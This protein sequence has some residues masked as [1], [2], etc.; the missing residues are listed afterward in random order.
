M[1]YWKEGKQH[2]IGKY[3]DENKER[4]GL[5][6]EGKKEKWLDVDEE[7]KNTCKEINQPFLHLFTLSFEEAENEINKFQNNFL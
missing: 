2:G 5:W 4:Y 1:A 7:L 3:I 6:K